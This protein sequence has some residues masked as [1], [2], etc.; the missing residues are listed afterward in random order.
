MENWPEGPA[1]GRQAPPRLGWTASGRTGGGGVSRRIRANSTSAESARATCACG[2]DGRLGRAG[3][4]NDVESA[5]GRSKPRRARRVRTRTRAELCV[6][7]CH[8]ASSREVWH[9]N[10]RSSTRTPVISLVYWRAARSNSMWTWTGQPASAGVA[11]QRFPYSSSSSSASRASRDGPSTSASRGTSSASS[12][13]AARRAVLAALLAARFE[14]FPNLRR[15]VE[16]V[17]VASVDGIRDGIDRVRHI[18]RVR[19]VEFVARPVVTTVV[20][21][22]YVVSKRLFLDA[23]GIRARLGR[24]ILG[25]DVQKRRSTRRRSSS[26]STPSRGS[27]MCREDRRRLVRLRR[28]RLLGGSLRARYRRLRLLREFGTRGFRDGDGVRRVAHPR[29]R[30]GGASSSAIR[31]GSSPKSAAA[32]SST[33]SVSAERCRSFSVRRN[34]AVKASYTRRKSSTR[35]LASQLTASAIVVASWSPLAS[36]SG[37]TSRRKNSRSPAG[38]IR[39]FEPGDRRSAASLLLTKKLATHARRSSSVAAEGG[40]IHPG[41]A[42]RS[43]NDAAQRRRPFLLR[44]RRILG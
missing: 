7:G 13:R 3:D 16:P 42:K 37:S 35:R 17:V 39:D 4:S 23:L 12:P 1:A 9:S 25:D 43:P 24:E 22:S 10:I 5:R 36:S 15:R 40:A 44:D 29:V 11:R 21:I 33:C 6:H 34:F 20:P 18:V 27:K 41:D 28:V 26:R 14:P 38:A 2:A 32:S 31:P 19:R 30:G 8:G